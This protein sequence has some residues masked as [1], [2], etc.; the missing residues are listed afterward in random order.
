[1]PLAGHQTHPAVLWR[2][3]LPELEALTSAF[4]AF[5]KGRIPPPLPCLLQ[6]CEDLPCAPWLPELVL[7]L[8]S[9]CDVPSKAPGRGIV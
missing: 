8:S 4:I 5:T 7:L 3:V 1:M 6:Q 2:R 9:G